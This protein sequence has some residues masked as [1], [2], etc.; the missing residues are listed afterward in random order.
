VVILIH[1]LHA[2]ENEFDQN[3]ILAATKSLKF[4]LFPERIPEHLEAL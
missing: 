1:A 3:D 4:N 2:W